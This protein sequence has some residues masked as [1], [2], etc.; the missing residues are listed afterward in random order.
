MSTHVDLLRRPG[1]TPLRVLVSQS[2]VGG[3][4]TQTKQKELFDNRSRMALLDRT[5]LIFRCAVC[6]LHGTLVSRTG[7]H[8]L[9]LCCFARSDWHVSSRFQLWGAFSDAVPSTHSWFVHVNTRNLLVKN[10]SDVRAR[11]FRSHQRHE[12]ISF[13]RA[14]LIRTAPLWS[15]TRTCASRVAQL[16]VPNRMLSIA[17]HINCKARSKVCPGLMLSC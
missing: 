14:C 10:M 5:D 13:F 2:F 15:V 17:Q 9:Q 16:H 3:R 6:L 7:A 12:Q 11:G 8:A 1:A 4:H